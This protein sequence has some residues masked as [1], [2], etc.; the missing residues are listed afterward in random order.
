MV[1][2]RPGR[3]VSTRV[4]AEAAA[5]AGTAAETARTAAPENRIGKRPAPGTGSR[6]REAGLVI[7]GALR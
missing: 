1:Q 6:R 5:A 7:T 2:D 3:A 4:T